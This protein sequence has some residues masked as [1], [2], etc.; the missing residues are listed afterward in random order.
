M[1]K[2]MKGMKIDRQVGDR[3]SQP[4]CLVSSLMRPYIIRRLSVQHHAVYSGRYHHISLFFCALCFVEVDTSYREMNICYLD[5][6]MTS[7]L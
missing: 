5:V 1:E 4:C 2:T 3:L 6:R 7:S